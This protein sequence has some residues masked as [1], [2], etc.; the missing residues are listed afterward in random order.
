METV[1]YL[2]ASENLAATMERV[3]REHAPLIIAGENSQA[4]VVV[5]LEDYEA[6]EETA[7]LLK[8]PANAQRLLQAVE[9]LNKGEG[10]QRTVDIA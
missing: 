6:L 1:S 8:S 5:S 4:V 9:A 10:I 3:C 7:Y 2:E